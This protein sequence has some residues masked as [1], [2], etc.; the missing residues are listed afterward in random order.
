MNYYKQFIS[1]KV[2]NFIFF[3]TNWLLKRGENFG[4]KNEINF[5]LFKYFYPN[6]G[7]N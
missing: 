7:C 2:N 1:Y 5:D 4:V 6:I 3:G